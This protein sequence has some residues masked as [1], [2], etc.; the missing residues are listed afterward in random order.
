MNDLARKIDGPELRLA[1]AAGPELTLRKL[2]AFWA[3]AQSQSLTGA[4]KLLGIAQPSLSQQIIGLEQSLGFALFTRRSN[5]MILTEAGILLLRKAEPV[6]RGMQELE[7]T[8]ATYAS[9]ARHPLRLAGVESLLRTILPEALKH[10]DLDGTTE[11]D[12]LEGAP[13]DVLEM[14]YSRRADIGLLAANS[15]SEASTGFLQIP[16]MNDPTVLAVP[17]AVDLGAVRRLEDLPEEQQAILNASIQIAFGTQHSRRIESWFA[18]MLPRNRM[19]ARVRSFETALSMVRAGLGVCIVPALSVA[20]APGLRLY[21]AGME[22]RRIVALIQPA[23]HRAGR[24]AAVIEALRAAGRAVRLPPIA[25]LPPLL[26][27]P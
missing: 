3:V 22:P 23:Q 18:E 6:L 10:L 2:R 9:G 21:H 4:A 20:Q 27:R 19:T 11:C 17:E 12:L 15:V 5:R 13:A 14:L 7:D 26:A 24:H 8:L 1:A 25:P 16:I